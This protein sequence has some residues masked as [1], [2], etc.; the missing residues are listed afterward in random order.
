MQEIKK[1]FINFNN[2]TKVIL[3][4]NGEIL[5]EPV[6]EVLV[7]GDPAYKEMLQIMGMPT[8]K[9]ASGAEQWEEKE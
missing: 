9:P 3:K 6:M 4:K 8:E 1:R 2:V 7:K 5:L